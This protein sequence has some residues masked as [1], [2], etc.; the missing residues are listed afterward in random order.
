MSTSSVPFLDLG[1]LHSSIRHELDSAFDAVV[2]ASSFVGGGTSANFEAAF[3][4]AHGRRFAVGCGSGTD[5]LILALRAA[6]IAPGDEVIVPGMTF[7]ASATAVIHAGATPVFADIDPIDMLVSADAVRKARTGRTKAII[8]VHLYGNLVSPDLLDS[9]RSE[10]LIVVEDAAQAHLAKRAGRRVGDMGQISCFSFYPSK[11]LGA[12]GDA[13]LVMTDDPDYAEAA[14]ELRDHGYG[15]DK[16]HLIV[17]YCSRL[18]GLQAAMLEVKLRHLPEW[19]EG[20]RVAA[21]H[22]RKRLGDSKACSLVEWAPG[23]VH[24]LL[25]VRVAAAERDRIRKDLDQRGIGTGIH[26]PSA[27]SQQPALEPWRRPCPEAERAAAEILSLP[28]D[29]LMTTD[30][31]DLVCDALEEVAARP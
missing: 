17:G 10:G 31:V 27:L 16:T 23:A 14:R 18:D 29:P 19:T 13:G 2:G 21:E 22:Y 7:I 20:R 30:D 24:H 6:G 3:A 12:L 25:V 1:R 5:A 8:P 4:E 15:P 26:Y 11:N 28:M 9:W